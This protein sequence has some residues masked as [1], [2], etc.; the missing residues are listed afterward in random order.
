[1]IFIVFLLICLLFCA[2][3][4][5][6]EGEALPEQEESPNAEADSVVQSVDVDLTQLSSTMVYGEVFAIT[7]APE[8]YIGKTIR[9]SG[10]YYSTY[11]DV[12]DKNYHFVVIADASACCQQGIE[13]LLPD[14]YA[15]PQDYPK[16]GDELEIS[17][18]FKSYEE[19]GN[20]YYYIE[21]L[22]L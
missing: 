2:C 10:E 18:V 14:T 7:D 6:A 21:V 17:G 13:F 1:M 12:T 8:L 4:N 19:E 9:L 16:N 3:A 11:Y 20:T 15:Y 22:K 5:K